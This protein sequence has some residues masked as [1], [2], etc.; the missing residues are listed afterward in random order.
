MNAWTG[1]GLVDE[2]AWA[3]GAPGIGCIDRMNRDNPAP[4]RGKS[5]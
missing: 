4:L 2:V 3:H 5:E 1:D